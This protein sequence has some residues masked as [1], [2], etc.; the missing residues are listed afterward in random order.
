MERFGM[1]MK[2][3]REREGLSQIE[4]ANKLGIS[5]SAV[6]NYEQGIR[7][8]D[9]ETEERIADFFGIDLDSLRGRQKGKDS[10]KLNVL[11]Y[12]AAGI[13]LEMITE[14]VDEEEISAQMAKCG[15]YFALRIKGN[16]MQP[17]IMDGDNVIV[18]V[19]PDVDSGDIAIVAVDGE[20]ATCKIIKKSERGITL[21]PKNPE[22]DPLFFTNEEVEQI[23]VT[24]L[25]KVVELR[26]K[27]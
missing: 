19:Q 5:R 27:L 10:V 17:V 21:I 14:I 7:E 22:Y 6:G 12:V 26:R 11:G 4:L 8:P 16:S 23:P 20:N 24:I 15:E 9:F 1:I 13:P 18:K 3:Y 2:S 25:G